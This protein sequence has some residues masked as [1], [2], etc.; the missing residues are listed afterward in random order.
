MPVISHISSVQIDTLLQDVTG[1]IP[2]TSPSSLSPPPG[3]TPVQAKGDGAELVSW[4]KDGSLLTC[5]SPL[6]VNGFDNLRF[7]GGEILAMDDLTDIGITT[8]EDQ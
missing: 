5:A 3:H 7:L 6:E 4:L 2:P 1:T 8:T